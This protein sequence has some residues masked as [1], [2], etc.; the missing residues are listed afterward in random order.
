MKMH[1]DETRVNDEKI[2]N[3]TM[4]RDDL[5]TEHA[6]RIIDDLNCLILSMKEK[7]LVMSNWYGYITDDPEAESHEGVGV[8]NR[9]QNYLPIDGA[10]DDGRFPWYLYWEIVSV[11]TGEPQLKRNDV[12]LDA[13]GTSSLFSCYLS[14]LGLDVH[15]IDLNQDIIVIGDQLAS[16]MGW[17][18]TS[19]QMDMRK[20]DY[21]DDF[22][23]HAFSV[24]VFEHLDY[25]VK[26]DALKEISRVLK[27]G[28]VLRVTF[29]YKNPAPDVHG[30]G[31]DSGLENALRN[32]ADIRRSF[33]NTDKFGLLGNQTFH[34]NGK[35]YLVNHRLGNQPYTFGVL[36]LVNVK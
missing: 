32:E 35:T 6:R 36:H 21:P 17:N 2:L 18:M 3:K 22:F 8:P 16:G 29:D 5:D 7:S 10:A 24:C 33:L 15:S 27:P 31:P 19:R 26:Q 25:Q 13:G 20:L 30:K 11:M 1:T 4:E 14:S 12:V 23:D 9:G 28:G 34:D